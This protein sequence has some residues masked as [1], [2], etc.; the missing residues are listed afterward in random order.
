MRQ[1][2]RARA[3]PWDLFCL[4]SR[5]QVPARFPEQ[6]EGTAGPETRED[7]RRANHCLLLRLNEFKA[8]HV[9]LHLHRMTCFC[10]HFCLLSCISS[11]HC[12]HGSLSS[13]NLSAP[14][15]LSHS[16]KSCIAPAFRSQASSP[17]AFAPVSGPRWAGTHVP[18]THLSMAQAW[19]CL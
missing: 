5:Q 18:L 3:G 10:S 2:R 14:S 1:G 12:L 6:R 16:P 11:A 17:S 13:N 8:R 15:A 19:D 7:I 9:S 4:T